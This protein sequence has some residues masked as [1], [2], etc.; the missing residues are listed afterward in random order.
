MWDDVRREL[1]LLE[2]DTE[3]TV[4]GSLLAEWS[5]TV[6]AL[7]AAR[8]AVAPIP[9]HDDPFA[10]LATATSGAL[11]ADT[12]EGEPVSS[13]ERV[14][15]A[16]NQGARAVAEVPPA[17]RSGHL[18]NVTHIAYELAHWARIQ[19]TDDRVRAWLLAGEI[20][21]DGAIHAPAAR[22][23]TSAGLAAWQGA[24]ATSMRDQEAAILQ[25]GVA[26]A[27]LSIL[28]SVNGPIGGATGSGALPDDY[29]RAVLDSIRDL[30]LSHQATVDALGGLPAEI[31]REHQ[32]VLLQLGTAAR[33]LS[34]RPDPLED[35]AGRLDALL[36]SG[37][38]Q[39]RLVADL[40]A[41]PA[42]RAPADRLQRLALEYLANPRMPQRPIAA[43]PPS[44]A[45][46]PRRDRTV[47]TPPSVTREPIV[48]TIAPGSILDEDTVRALCQTRDLGAAASLA[49]PSHPPA[50]LRDTDPAT[51]PRLATAG[52]AAVADLV[53]SVT[54]MVYALTRNE[55]NREDMRGEM[56]VHLMRVAHAY[57]P[58]RTVT[59]QVVCGCQGFPVVS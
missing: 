47:P 36:R 54:P 46:T 23:P 19:A 24:L 15:A 39:A 9:G 1:R 40:T 27:H 12:G 30:G 45:P 49:D 34:G 5:A 2:W 50:S 43:E 21:L 18:I 35:P 13:L 20:S 14:R 31:S 37:I 52:Q 42:A 29:G 58:A 28:K 56:F 22:T 38:G 26:L 51:W 7:L 48:A 17:E 25:R 59:G 8:R 44:G 33:Q 3:S 57:D 4:G 10:L 53:A 6:T 32:A 11:R 55:P 16:L 41:N